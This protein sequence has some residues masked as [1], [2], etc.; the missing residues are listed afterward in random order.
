MKKPKKKKIIKMYL[1]NQV[2]VYT[3]QVKV[4]YRR[5]VS[6]CNHLLTMCNNRIQKTHCIC[7]PRVAHKTCCLSQILSLLPVRICLLPFLSFSVAGFTIAWEMSA[8]FEMGLP[9]CLR[10][11]SITFSRSFFTPCSVIPG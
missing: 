2:L 5:R 11:Y 10:L 9:L 3:C 1:V 6:S 4:V 8:V 7:F